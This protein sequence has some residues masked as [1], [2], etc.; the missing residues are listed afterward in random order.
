MSPTE[1]K[2][3][4]RNIILTQC[5]AIVALG[6]I[7]NGTLLLYLTAIGATAVHTMIYLAIIPLTNAILLLP[8]AYLADRYGKKRLGQIGLSIGILGWSIISIGAF[9]GS[10][11]ESVIVIG[12]VL[13][14]ICSSLMGAG[15]FSLLSPI[16]PAAIR[17]RFFSRLRLSFSTV[18]LTLSITYA[19]LLSIHSGIIVYQG[20]FAL[21][22]LA[23]MLRWFTYHR[24]PELEPPNR[25]NTDPSFFTVISKVFR[26]KNLAAFCSYIFLLGLFTAGAAAL[27][28]MVEKRVL[29]FSATRIILLSNITLIGSMLG[30]F[31]GGRIVD[32][33]GPRL[34]FAACHVML[35]LTLMGFLLRI[36]FPPSMLVAH[37]CA[38]HFLLGS[39]LGAIGIAMTSEL[40]GILP[41]ENKSVASSMFIIF[42]TSGVA[43]SGLIPAWILQV[44]ILRDNWQI[45]ARQLSSFDA[46]LL[47]YSIMTLILVATLGLIP[48]VLRKS[49]PASLGI[50]RL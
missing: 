25:K 23:F 8:A 3:A 44:G 9:F 48:S 38:M 26:V 36:F 46:I 20:I 35:A 33:H 47:G 32:R 40:L 39:A 2:A 7:V 5:L 22:A 34:V 49:E 19:W 45:G 13:A 28:A 14:A 4:L 18:S 21:A 37:L 15:W 17:G 30:M 12:I 42:Q 41:Q 27:F 50:N 10:S 1:E 24:I 16:I 6:T 11:S 43:L 31:V 29:D